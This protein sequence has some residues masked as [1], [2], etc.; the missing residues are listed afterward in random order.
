MKQY[1]TKEIRCLRCNTKVGVILMT[2]PIET[3]KALCP[4]CA[5][6]VQHFNG[7]RAMAYNKGEQRMSAVEDCKN[8]Q[9]YYKDLD[10]RPEECCTCF[11]DDDGHKT[12][13][14][15]LA[16]SM[17]KGICY[18]CQSKTD[19]CQEGLHCIRDSEG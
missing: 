9:I 1:E 10:Y 16:I 2:E 3:V 14:V 15:P 8:C 12:E 17:D 4:T 7:G 18:N 6:I 5:Y 11:I 13:F 19:S